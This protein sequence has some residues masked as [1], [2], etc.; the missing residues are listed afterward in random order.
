MTS[1]PPKKQ[2]N[3]RKPDVFVAGDAPYPSRLVEDENDYI[4][5]EVAR[6]TYAAV[7]E[8][9]KEALAVQDVII[10]AI[11]LLAETGDSSTGNHIPRIQNYVRALAINLQKHPRFAQA[12]T[13]PQIEL[14]FKFAPLHDIGKVGIP[15]RI[16]LKPG[17]LTVEEFEIMKTHTTLGWDAIN[18]AEKSL[19]TQAEFLTMAKDIALFHQEKWDGSGYPQGR[20]GDAIPIS[21]RLM[22]VADV[23]DAL[24]SRR[25]Y[26]EGLPHEVAVAIILKGKGQHFDPDIVDAF[27]RLQDEFLAIAQRY[28]DSDADLTVKAEQFREVFTITNPGHLGTP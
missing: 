6:R 7:K 27:A 8:A 9:N 14:L 15:D 26:K 28:A 4:E 24:I 11:T 10:R 2:K 21:A 19:G 25:V 23:Y 17:K 5:Q 13:D 20:R 22:A 1:A 16:L 12:L 3:P 18:K